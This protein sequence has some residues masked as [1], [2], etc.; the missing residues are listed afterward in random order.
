M[1][2]LFG[3][4]LVQSVPG[5]NFRT[6]F[7]LPREGGIS[8]RIRATTRCR[9]AKLLWSG[10]HM[11]WMLPV[12]EALRLGERFPRWRSRECAFC[13]L[14]AFSWVSSRFW[15]SLLRD[16]WFG[17]IDIMYIWISVLLC[18]FVSRMH[19]LLKYANAFPAYLGLFPRIGLI[20]C[21][22]YTY[23]YPVLYTEFHRA[24]T[25]FCSPCASFRFPGL[26]HF[27]RLLRAYICYFV[28]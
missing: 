8:A 9:G 15:V 25:I 6:I 21:R 13:I 3:V 20:L 24:A 22:R 16:P 18:N 1:C 28:F 7:S 11:V 17:C 19:F 23:A 12:P 2:D 4:R 5:G 10:A 14:S 26:L 27:A